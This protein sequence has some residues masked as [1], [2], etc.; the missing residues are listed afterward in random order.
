[1]VTLLWL[2]AGCAAPPAPAPSMEAERALTRLSLDL[3]GRRPDPAELAVAAADPTALDRY[4]DL[5]LRGPELGGRVRDLWSEVYLTRSDLWP[6]SA[7]Q[8]S[9]RDV[10]DFEE[11]VG[12]EDLRLLGWVAENDLPWTDIV[13]AD[14]T[15]ANDTL[16]EVWPLEWVEGEPAEGGWARA[17]YTDGRPAAGVLSTNSLWWRYPSSNANA[18]RHRA[19]A[20]S[21]IL[22]CDDYLARPIEFDR[23]VNLLDG[24]AVDDAVKNNPNCVTCHASLDPIASYLFGFWW[25]ISF[26]PAEV[27]YYQPTRELLW[28]EYLGVPPAWYGTPGYGLQDLGHQIAGDPRFPNCATQQAFEL[29]LRRDAAYED[30]E[31][32]AEHRDAFIAGGL[33]MRA[34]LGSVLRDPAYLAPDTDEAG[35][36]PRKMVTPDLLASQTT[37]LTGFT[38]SSGSV[39]YMDSSLFG[40]HTLAGGADG[41]TVTATATSPSTTIVLVQ[42]R[43]AEAAAS[44][45]VETG[46]APVLAGLDLDSRPS[47]ADLAALTL[48]VL[49]RTVEPTD[50]E[51]A[52]LIELWDAAAAEGG[53][54]EAWAT[55]L[56]ALMR[57]PDYLFY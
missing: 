17:R 47:E 51:V 25:Y 42:Q 44:E 35:F 21:R 55:V 1:M 8:Y 27:S 19:N 28:Q 20:V 45:A 13:T 56:T 30:T 48:R 40:F 31:A 2:Y 49:S 36:V 53:A 43:L 32:L 24:E 29:L 41:S 57:D 22:L 5:W 4:T 34:L 39:D 7:S 26:S 14:W 3:R 46:T 38:W 52:E 6:V 23:N 12:E 33:T 10:P 37:A 18:N 15:V 9:R 11:S 16:A 50:T 54:R